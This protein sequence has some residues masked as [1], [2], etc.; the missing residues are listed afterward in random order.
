MLMYNFPKDLRDYQREK[1]K[2][3]IERIEKGDKKLIFEGQTGIGKTRIAIELLKYLKAKNSS[4]KAIVVVDRIALTQNPW[5]KELEKWWPELIR[6]ERYTIVYGG[7]RK[8]GVG[9]TVKER[10]K[11]YKFINEKDL[12]LIT[13]QT[14]H[15][16]IRRNII[17]LEKFDFFIFDEAHKVVTEAE[18]QGKYRYSVYYKNLVLRLLIRK[19]S[20]ILGLT[21]PD[22]QRTRETENKLKATPVISNAPAPEVKIKILSIESDE[23]L[24]V[25]EIFKRTMQKLRNRLKDIL[26]NKRPERVKKERFEEILEERKLNEK[27]KKKYMRDFSVYKLLFQARLC[28]WEGI[29]IRNFNRVI[30]Y[31]AKFNSLSYSELEDLFETVCEKKLDAVIKLVKRLAEEGNKIMVYCKYKRTVETLYES[32]EYELVDKKVAYFVGGDPP[33]KLKEIQDCDVVIFSPVA[34]EGL[35]LPQFD[36]LVH[37]SGIAGEFT[38]KQ[39]M[40]RIRG[41]EVYYVVFQDTNDEEKLISVY[42]EWEVVLDRE[43]SYEEAYIKIP[44]SD[45]G[46][47]KYEILRDLSQNVSK[48]EYLPIEMPTDLTTTSG[49]G[50]LGEKI[51]EFH[52]ELKGYEVLPLRKAAKKKRKWLKSRGLTDLQIKFIKENLAIIPQSPLDLIAFLNKPLIIEV[53]T[54]RQQ[55]PLKLE[56][57]QIKLLD[58]AIEVG[59]NVA[60]ASVHVCEAEE[61]IEAEVSFWYPMYNNFN[62]N[63]ISL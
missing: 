45:S 54:S 51:V 31:L 16:D 55:S 30:E 10:E 12:L 36:I 61:K 21:I 15:N 13:V 53:K 19:D 39:I 38:R 26:G 11:I 28:I 18:E 3:L 33:Y 6:N 62:K 47:I 50:K 44:L 46:K 63:V 25:D 57:E 58:K 2:E 41:G 56:K 20:I 7:N 14:L 60:I 34:K 32:L 8:K 29:K 52:L 42:E 59:F 27:E 9:F 5:K 43:T 4:L 24:T 48:E 40:G 37:V 1:L 17:D 22:T 49:L 23:A 35:D